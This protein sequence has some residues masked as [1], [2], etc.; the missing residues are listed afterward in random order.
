MV[1]GFSP[2]AIMICGR[3]SET[4]PRNS[5]NQKMCAKCSREQNFESIRESK[6]RV[7]AEMQAKRGP[8]KFQYVCL[9]CD[10]E[11]VSHVINTKRCEKCNAIHRKIDQRERQ[12]RHRQKPETQRREYN[13]RRSKKVLEKASIADK[14]RRSTL[15]GKLENAMNNGIIRGLRKG[16][17]RGRSVFE[18]LG[19]SLEDLKS[20]LE[21]QFTDGMSWENMGKWHIDHIIPLSVHNYNCPDDVDFRKAW[22]LSNLQPLWGKENMAKHNRLKEPFQ[23]S[24]AWS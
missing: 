3:C 5:N 10:K 22:C 15:R 1:S 20:H 21:R 2:G 16:S 24:F 4:I 9:G 19:F 18:I 7:R 8:I 6:R 23:P 11:L 14:K 13:Y 17:K 12:K